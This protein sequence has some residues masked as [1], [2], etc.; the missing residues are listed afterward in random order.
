M[1]LWLFFKPIT[2]LKYLINQNHS[3]CVRICK[4][5]AQHKLTE[6]Q[7]WHRLDVNTVTNSHLGPQDARPV[8]VQ[9]WPLIWALQPRLQDN[10]EGT[11]VISRLL[12]TET[13]AKVS[14][15]FMCLLNTHTSVNVTV[16]SVFVCF[17][18]HSDLDRE[19]E[20]LAALTSRLQNQTSGLL[21]V[22]F[23]QN[24]SRRKT[25]LIQHQAVPNS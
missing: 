10:R 2:L 12:F 25:P 23:V 19:A 7:M 15:M 21:S 14:I 16:V 24:S 6:T 5:R 18:G 8:R 20:T 11:S 1:L 3:R 22:W 4:S 9:H 17:L 13:S